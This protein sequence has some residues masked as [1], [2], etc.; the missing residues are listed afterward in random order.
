MDWRQLPGLPQT[1]YRSAIVYDRARERMSEQ[2]LEHQK[3]DESQGKRK[4][5]RARASTG[6]QSAT[7]GSV[8]R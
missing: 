4:G 2:G 8:T 3:A 5:P 7:E 6:A 1:A